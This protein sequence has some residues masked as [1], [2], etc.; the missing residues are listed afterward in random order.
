MGLAQAQW[1][2][3]G[4]GALFTFSLLVHIGA[5]IYDPATGKKRPEEGK[6]WRILLAIFEWLPFISIL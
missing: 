6:S 2:L 5:A 4:T 1:V 3:L